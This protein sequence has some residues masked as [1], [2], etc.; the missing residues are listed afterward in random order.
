VE[1]RDRGSFPLR[2]LV[3]FGNVVSIELVLPAAAS[4][5][6]ESFS[7]LKLVF[8]LILII[9]SEINLRRGLK[10]QDLLSGLTPLLVTSQSPN[11]AL[12][13]P[14]PPYIISSPPQTFKTHHTVCS[15][16]F[17]N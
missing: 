3:K 12:P 11:L 13:A 6:D 9:M 7:H 10:N 8:E 4:E 16:L 14:R 17:S 2:D 15:L 1:F 5:F